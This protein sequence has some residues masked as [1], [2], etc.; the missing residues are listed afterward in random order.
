[1][2]NLRRCFNQ[3]FITM[4]TKLLSVFVLLA[5]ALVFSSC[6]KYE[7]GGPFLG[8]KKGVLA[9]DWEFDDYEAFVSD[10]EDHSSVNNNDYEEELTFEKDGTFDGEITLN[11]TTT[12]DVEGQWEF[13][14]DQKF[15]RFVMESSSG[16]ASF[17]S[18]ETLK[19][20]KLKKDE[21]ILEE[22]DGD[23]ITYTAI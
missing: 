13:V 22:A 10:D 21:L 14:D 2:I 18:G 1:M 3:N 15:I 4:K 11:S 8:S 16:G 12:V 7:E 5:G 6:S 19:I 20:I 17:S 9:R 23:L